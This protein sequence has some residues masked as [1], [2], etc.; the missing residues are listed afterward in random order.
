MSESENEAVGKTPPVP[1]R[2]KIIE[3]GKDSFWYLL[4]SIVT[5]LLGFIAVPIFT[6][7]LTP[8]EYGIYSL[9]VSGVMLASPFIYAWLSA[10]VLRFYP[11]Y[12]KLDKLDTFYSTV[13][14]F[15]PYFLVFFLLIASPCVALFVPL[16]DY[17]AAVVAG[18]VVFALYSTAYI[19]NALLRA[20]QLAWQYAFLSILNQSGRYLLGA[21]LIAWLG[22][23][24]EGIIIGWGVTIAIAIPLAL[25]WA[26]APKHFSWKG[27][28]PSLFHQFFSYGFVLVFT[29][30]LGQVLTSGDRYVLQFIKGPSSVGIYTVVYSLSAAVASLSVSFISMGAAPVVIKTYE[31]EGEGAAVVLINRVTRYILLL[32]LPSMFGI[33]ALRDRIFTVI[34]SPR[35][36]AGSVAL[37]PLAIGFIFEFIGWPAM[38]N[39]VLK[40]KTK[41]FAIPAAT[42]ALVNIGLNFALIPHFGITGA[43]VAT[44][45]SYMLHFVILTAISLRYMRWSFPWLDAIKIAFATSV[46]ALSLGA[47]ESLEIGGVFGLLILILLGAAIYFA[48]F[49]LV[50]GFTRNEIDTA[51]KIASK[52]PLLGGLFRFLRRRISERK[53]D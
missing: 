50:R 4:A 13:L 11:E 9:V 21:A 37:L 22:F 49:L 36:L 27:Y 35:Y 46:M 47:L 52:V 34:T 48:V 31:F 14:H 19:C 18:I 29:N 33:W 5:S 30:F 39:I 28:D 20:R 6:R 26:S 25:I 23:G 3:I 10:S 44:M 51:L 12:K 43:A 1:T 15:L 24:P 38:T 17:K 45:I 7:I 41:L 16:G 2:H 42:S 53:N 8:K 32:L 40:K